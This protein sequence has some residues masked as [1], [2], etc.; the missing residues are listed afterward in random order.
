MKILKNLEEKQKNEVKEV[1]NKN[2]KLEEK[3]NELIG[4][5]KE[6]KEVISLSRQKSAKYNYEHDEDDEKRI[7]K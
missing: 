2:K 5:N 7:L 3:C 6:L 1:E 4:K